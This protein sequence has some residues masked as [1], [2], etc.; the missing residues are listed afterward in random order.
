MNTAKRMITPTNTG[1][2][3]V[4]TGNTP[5][6]NVGD[7][8]YAGVIGTRGVIGVSENNVIDSC[9]FTNEPSTIKP[10]TTI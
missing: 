4:L 1:M 9:T 7:V 8:E 2:T 6:M 3:I 10:V 5:G